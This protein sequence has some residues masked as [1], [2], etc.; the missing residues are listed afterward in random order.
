MPVATLGGRDSASIGDPN[1]L[2]RLRDHERPVGVAVLGGG[3]VHPRG[4]MSEHNDGSSRGRDKRRALSA[5]EK[6]QI[7]LQ[8]L[9]GEATQRQAAERWDVDPTTIMRIRRVA[10]AGVLSAL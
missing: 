1:H 2:R 4:N 3:H 8:L 10:R 6:L 9:A 5:E 7:W